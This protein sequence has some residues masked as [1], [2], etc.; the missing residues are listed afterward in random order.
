MFCPQ[1]IWASRQGGGG[2]AKG[3]FE[4]MSREHSFPTFDP[5]KQGGGWRPKLCGHLDFADN[6]QDL[7]EIPVRAPIIIPLKLISVR[8]P[9]RYKKKLFLRGSLRKGSFH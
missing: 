3:G 6:L 1:K 9:F 7:P 2:G 5:C 4:E 8:A